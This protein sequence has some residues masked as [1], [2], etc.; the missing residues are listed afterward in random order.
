[1][2]FSEEN[3]S[4]FKILIENN[5]SMEVKSLESQ[6]TY[7]KPDDDYD[8]HSYRILLLIYI[9]GIQNIA[10]S[11]FKLIYGRWKF[12]FY[13]FLIRYPF[14]MEKT[15]KVKIPQK[16]QNAFLE[17][18]DINSFET[19]IAFSEM[20]N[21]L[22]GPWDHNYYNIFAY[23]ASKDLLKISHEKVTPKGTNVFCIYLTELGTNTAMKIFQFE[24]LWCNRMQL[25]NEIFKENTSDNYIDR[26]IGKEFP[27][28]K[29]GK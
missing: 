28:L 25:I 27:E 4:F 16:K 26:F 9:C 5:I 8:F 22:R 17:K 11:D 29:I 19:T 14:Y 23:L 7:I 6:F 24:D 15:I 20:S 2:K 3:N 21:Y 18:L 12:A 13:D 1:M 10:I